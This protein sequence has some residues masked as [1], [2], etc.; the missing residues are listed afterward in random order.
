MPLPR[1]RAA[2]DAEVAEVVQRVQARLLPAA[3]DE[4][5]EVA[6]HKEEIQAWLEGRPPLRLSR[7]HALL[8]TKYKLAASY[9]TLRR[10]VQAELGWGKR[11]VTVRLDDTKP[12]EVAQVDFGKMGVLRD[13]ESGKLRSL[14]AL[15]VT[16]A[17]SRYQFVW[18]C[19]FQTTEEVCA[20][21]DAAWKFFGGVTRVILPDNM[22]SIINTADP[23]APKFV[24]AFAE[25]AQARG[26]F[27]DSARVRSPKDKARVENQVPFVRESCFAGE[28]LKTLDDA[29][30]R[31]DAWCRDVA[32]ARVHGTT[33]RVPR[34]VFT[35]EELPAMRPPPT[36]RFDVPVWADAKVHPDHHIQVAKALYSVPTRF[37]G[38]TVRVRVDRASVRIHLGAEL[39]K[40]HARVAPGKRA[41]DLTDD[42]VGKGEIAIRDVASLLM[43]SITTDRRP[44]TRSR[45]PERPRPAPTSSSAISSCA[46]SNDATLRSRRAA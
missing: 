3:S 24:E 44:V 17:Y 35:L 30:L 27:V 42:P 14:W 22:S 20:G 2:T 39:I 38:K 31:A 37:I 40:M 12:G 8:V 36:E 34:D 11:R 10:F 16:L 13:P 5:I 45:D 6:A 15:I 21:L 25:Y 29:R 46:A 7:I 32:G 33:R 4:R 9:A 18:P 43:S 26:F 23:L 1:D 19:F 28:V 41:A